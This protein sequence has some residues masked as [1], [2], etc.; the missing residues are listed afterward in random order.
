MGNLTATNVK[1][2]NVERKRLFLWPTRRM[3]DRKELRPYY[4]FAGFRCFYLQILL[5]STH[6][7]IWTHL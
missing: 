6:T 7:E 2:T 5:F 3:S 4:T 1:V